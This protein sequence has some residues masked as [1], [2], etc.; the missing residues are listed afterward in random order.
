MNLSPWAFKPL[1][2]RAVPAAL[3]P[4]GTDAQRLLRPHVSPVVGTR[5]ATTCDQRRIVEIAVG[6]ERPRSCSRAFGNALVTRLKGGHG[7]A[8]TSTVRAAE[9]GNDEITRSHL[10]IPDKLLKQPPIFAGVP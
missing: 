5:G 9:D 4:T 3:A 6:L 1:R 2:E 7:R 8:G 10:K